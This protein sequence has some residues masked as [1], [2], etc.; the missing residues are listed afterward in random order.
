M[1]ETNMI[2]FTLDQ[3]IRLMVVFIRVG[4]L[5]FFMPVTGSRGVPVQARILCA[6]AA[7]LV[8]A[9][10]VGITSASLPQTGITLGLFVGKEIIF[11][12]ILALFSRLL[13]AAVE[14]AGQMAGI[15]MGLGIAGTM[16]PQNGTQTSLIGYFWNICA[17]LIFLAINGHHLFFRTMLESFRGVPPGGI[18]IT[19]ATFVGMVRGGSWMFLLA[20]KIMAPITAALFFTQVAMGVIA[21]TV[22]QIPI[23]IV[24]MPLNIGLGL[25]LTGMGLVFLTP[26]LLQEFQ[27]MGRLLTQLTIGLGG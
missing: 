21:K 13:F 25:T 1:P 22:P 24:A 26:L 9:P 19:Q 10:V 20:V 16:D 3:I 14:I 8:L 17:I 7:A 15:Q 27:T 12:A 4:P 23:L 6:F 2:N 11:G 18:H 5:I